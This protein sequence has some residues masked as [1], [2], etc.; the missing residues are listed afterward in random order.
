MKIKPV[1]SM[2]NLSKL[3]IKKRL[4]EMSRL[5]LI[6]KLMN[7]KK[8]DLSKVFKVSRNP[9]SFKFYES[10]DILLHKK[11]GDT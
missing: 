2:D 10:F 9:P 11:I 5:E 6:M 4:Y 7:N 1:G 8:V 3:K